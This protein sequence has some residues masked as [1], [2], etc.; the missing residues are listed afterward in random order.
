MRLAE[1]HVQ[2]RQRIGQ[3]SNGAHRRAGWSGIFVLKGSERL[4][5]Q[6]QE[7]GKLDTQNHHWGLGR[8]PSKLL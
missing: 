1:R 4:K 8:A 3:R 2:A 6:F 7:P 5:D